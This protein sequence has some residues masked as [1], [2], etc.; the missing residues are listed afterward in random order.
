MAERQRP[1]APIPYADALARLIAPLSPMAAEAGRPQAG[2]TLAAAIVAPPWP[3]MALAAIDGWAVA[4]DTTTGAGP[5]NP[6]PLVPGVSA[7]AVRVGD[8]LPVGCDAVIVPDSAEVLGSLLQAVEA[9]AAGAGVEAAGADWPGGTLLAAGRVLDPVALAALASAGIGHVALVGVPRVRLIVTGDAPVD[10]AAAL[11]ALIGRDGG[12]VAVVAVRD[13]QEACA[14]ALAAD[15]ADLVITTGG[16]GTGANDRTVAALAAVGRVDAHGIGLRPGGTTAFGVAFGLGGD[17]PA[18]LL[19]G[20]PAAALAAYEMLAGAA[21][22]RLCGRSCDLPHRVV[23][24]PLSRKLISS[25]GDVDVV[26]VRLSGAVAEPVASGEAAG[27]LAAGAADGFVV[28]PAG[29]EGLPAG[30]EI[31]VHL[32][33]WR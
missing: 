24:R 32:T 4:A 8:R 26:W 16:T 29:S 19:P 27:I 10:G 14:A 31:D 12:G 13:G 6:L 21:V 33:E 5:Y 11:A 25:A 2:R 9:A 17:R 20:R 23:R 28:L 18:I 1:L 22:R 30:A 7:H 3:P 15:G